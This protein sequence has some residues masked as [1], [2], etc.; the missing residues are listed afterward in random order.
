M[1]H[2][3]TLSPCP[4]EDPDDLVL[5]EH[6]Y[7][8]PEGAYSGRPAF[9]PPEGYEPRG[10]AWLAA[11]APDPEGGDLLLYLWARVFCLTAEERERR[12]QAFRDALRK[13]EAERRRLLEAVACAWLRAQGV[14]VESFDALHELYQR[15][16][17]AHARRIDANRRRTAKD[18]LIRAIMERAME[19]TKVTP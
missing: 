1:H 18:H 13:E 6:L 16:L 5:Y 17:L 3:L 4:S 15:D 7:V 12:E 10:P 19:A 9:R 11:I 2:A 14:P 8:A